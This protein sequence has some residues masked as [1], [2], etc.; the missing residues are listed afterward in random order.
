MQA[1]DVS[2]YLKDTASNTDNLWL[3]FASVVF[4][5]LVMAWAVWKLLNR[6][7]G[8]FL[9]QAL[10]NDKLKFYQDARIEMQK[11]AHKQQID[12]KSVV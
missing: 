2:K 5:P 11:Q 12:R 1:S 9:A 8:A 7:A 4:F 10:Y 3:L 6:G